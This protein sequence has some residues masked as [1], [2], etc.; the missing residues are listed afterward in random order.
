MTPNQARP[1]KIDKDYMTATGSKNNKNRLAK[2]LSTIR[3][4]LSILIQWATVFMIVV[5]AGLTFYFMFRLEIEV[6]VFCAF[7]MFIA[8]KV[9]NEVT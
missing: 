4:V 7:I 3:N 8:T 6:A 9:N 5:S 1:P 2:V